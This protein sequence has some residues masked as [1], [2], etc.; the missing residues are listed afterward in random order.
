MFSPLF[1][2]DATE[3]SASTAAQ[4]LVSALTVDGLDLA[5]LDFKAIFTGTLLAAGL[6]LLKGIVAL[7]TSDGNS[8]SLTIDNIKEK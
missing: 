2:R 3:R 5:N 4:F 1:W 7:K 6:S 8:A